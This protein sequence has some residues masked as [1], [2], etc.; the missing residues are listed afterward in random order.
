[1]PS[2]S[3]AKPACSK[4]PACG[5]WKEDRTYS[6]ESPHPAQQIPSFPR[7]CLV[8]K[9]YRSLRL[10]FSRQT[11]QIGNKL[12]SHGPAVVHRDLVHEPG[13]YPHLEGSS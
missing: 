1:M 6:W 11:L 5:A 12:E 13:H 9:G 2:F 4:A 8:L 3:Q 7:N 10:D